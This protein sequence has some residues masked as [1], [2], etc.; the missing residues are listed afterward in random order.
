MPHTKLLFTGLRTGYLHCSFNDSQVV[1]YA[2]IHIVALSYFLF[3][4]IRNCWFEA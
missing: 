4:N 3:I 1:F 2:V